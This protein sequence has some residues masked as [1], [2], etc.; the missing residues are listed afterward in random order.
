MALDS[1]IAHCLKVATLGGTI[2]GFNELSVLENLPHERV[3]AV[4]LLEEYYS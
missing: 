1:V 4:T 2:L 3:E